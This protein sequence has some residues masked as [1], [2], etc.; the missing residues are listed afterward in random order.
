MCLG[1][2]AEIV[3]ACDLAIASENAEFGLVEP[4]VGLAALGG[5]ALQRMARE[6]P[7][8]DAPAPTITIAAKRPHQKPDR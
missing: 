3:A 8:K 4:R 5:G 6:M 1:G 7:M 2:G